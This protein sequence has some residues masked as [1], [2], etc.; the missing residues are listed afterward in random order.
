MK[1]VE[2]LEKRIR[3]TD[4]KLISYDELNE[5]PSDQ[6][7][8][9][10]Q[11]GSIVQTD[12]AEGVICNQ[13]DKHCW[14][15]VETRQRD[16]RKIG[17]IRCEDEDCA[18]LIPVE[19]E[20]LQQWEIVAERPKKRKSKRKLKT[21]KKKAT[22]SFV[23]WDK[24]GDAC[25]LSDKGKICFYYKDTVKEIPLQKG[26]QA[27]VVLTAYLKGIQ[28]GKEIQQL[29]DSRSQPSQIVRNINRTLSEQ[30]RKI[31][32]TDIKDTC[33]IWYNEEQHYYELTPNITDIEKFNKAM[34]IKNKHTL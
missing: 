9:A 19:L 33:F 20:R 13:C 5:W 8:E 6:V 10:K 7:E 15:P 21:K 32:F 31:G 27:P 24:K 25:F 17:V 18:G 12:D 23:V 22:T 11:Q 4:N 26:S 29:A 34:N 14:K 30:L 2:Y 16:G 3:Q 1:L 28:D